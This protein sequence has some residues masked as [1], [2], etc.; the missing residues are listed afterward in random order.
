MKNLTLIG[1]SCL[2]GMLAAGCKSTPAPKAQFTEPSVTFTALESTNRLSSDLLRP[3]TGDF[4]LG[5]GDQLEIEIIGQ[6]A[7]RSRTAVGP[8]GKI[9]FHLL[10]GMDVWGMTL[11][12]T[13]Q[14]LEQGLS[15]YL[16]QP[17]VSLT[18][19][20]VG[21][22]HVWMVGR[23][24]RPGI[25]P[26]P[27]PI[28]LLEAIALAGGTARSVS[29]ANSEE[30]ADLRH[31]FVMRNGQALPVDFQ[32]LLREGDTSQNI[33]L[34][35]DDFVFIPSSLA[36]EVYVLGAVRNPRAIPYTETLT[37]VSVLTGADGPARFD[38]LARYEQ[39]LQNDAYLSQ[40][41]IVRGSLAEPQIAVVDF[42]AI[43]KGKAPNVKLEPG[44]IVYVPNSPYR[45]LKSYLNMVVNTFVSTVAAN[46]GIRAAGGDQG[47]SVSIPVTNQ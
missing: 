47:T 9:Y 10:P 20:A 46:E 5:P 42:G 6:P 19:R 36:Q 4:T 38:Y 23:L 8:D 12:Q 27:A 14:A 18:L 1:Y 35:P 16:S 31:S 25:Y 28:S 22:R 37:L 44:D 34:Q 26:M 24:N 32:R 29:P 17:Q 2:V 41:A 7:S 11:D 13:R 40:I 43:M 21:S 30:L 3:D 39:G 45:I 33:I 15:K